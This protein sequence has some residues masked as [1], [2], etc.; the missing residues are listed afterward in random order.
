MVVCICNCVSDKDITQ[1]IEI[2]KT[3]EEVVEE[4]QASTCCGKCKHY[5]EDMFQEKE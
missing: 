4:T 1:L 2:G 3:F 5:L